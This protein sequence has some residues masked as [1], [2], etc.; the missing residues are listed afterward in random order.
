MYQ[1]ALE[2]NEAVKLPLQYL[3][4]FMRK[5]SGQPIDNRLMIES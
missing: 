5:L 2:K 3:I 1:P 4:N